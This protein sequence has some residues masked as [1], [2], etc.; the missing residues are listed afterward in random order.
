MTDCVWK[1]QPTPYSYTNNT[2]AFET[3]SY[4]HT[5]PTTEL[6]TNWIFTFGG[7]GSS[8]IGPVELSHD[9][10]TFHVLKTHLPIY[11]DDIPWIHSAQR[12]H[13]CH[14]TL[15]IERGY[16]TTPPTRLGTSTS[17]PR[18]D[19]AGSAVPPSIPSR[20]PLNGRPLSSCCD[21]QRPCR[22]CCSWLSACS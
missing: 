22:C 1:G 11:L 20:F 10:S 17:S 12:Q 18:L 21:R 16:H 6:L 15:A 5:Q 4:C 8:G 19:G 2:F 7:Y 3:E 13:S 14:K 9:W